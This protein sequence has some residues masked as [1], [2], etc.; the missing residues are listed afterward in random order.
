MVA[1]GSDVSARPHLLRGWIG[2]LAACRMSVFLPPRADLVLT[3]RES[4][5]RSRS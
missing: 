4:A 2:G 1:K 5:A 3:R